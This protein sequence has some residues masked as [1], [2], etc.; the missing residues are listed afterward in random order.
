M[1]ATLSIVAEGS[2][3]PFFSCCVSVTLRHLVT[4]PFFSSGSFVEA[5]GGGRS[6]G[7][8]CGFLFIFLGREQPAQQDPAEGAGKRRVFAPQIIIIIFLEVGGDFEVS[9]D[10]GSFPETQLQEMS[11]DTLLEA[12]RFLEWQAQQ[13]TRGK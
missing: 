7:R 2:V 1:E 13:Q 10:F 6:F 11:I 12:A 9:Q 4:K 3:S 8:R 5:R